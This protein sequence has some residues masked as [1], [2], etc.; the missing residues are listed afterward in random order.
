M[1]SPNGNADADVVHRVNEVMY[2]SPKSQ[3]LW[4]KELTV[5]LGSLGFHKAPQ[6]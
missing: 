5:A 1:R 4:Q 3:L 6:E 2:S